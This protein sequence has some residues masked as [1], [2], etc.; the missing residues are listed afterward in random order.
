MDILTLLGLV[1]QGLPLVTG[2]IDALHAKA[3]APSATEADIALVAS[4]LPQA[5]ALLAQFKLIR[6]QTVDQYPQ[7]WAG[8]HDT[9][10]AAA[11]K[12]DELIALT[13]P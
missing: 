9:Y 6:D 5:S 12:N 4:L 3:T 11:A 8:I 2:L 10:A 13:A 7:V 1:S